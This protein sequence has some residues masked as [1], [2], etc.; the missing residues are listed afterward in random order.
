MIAT[1]YPDRITVRRSRKAKI[2][3]LYEKKLERQER[4][5]NQKSLDNLKIERQ[6]FALSKS[7]K[8]K[9][10]DTFSL[11]YSL[12]PERKIEYRKNKYIYNFRLSFVTLTLPSKQIHTDTEIK[13]KCLNNFLNIMRNRFGLKNYIW[14]AELQKNQNIHFHLVFDL[15]INHHAVRYYWNQS[16]ELLGYVSAY[17]AKFSKMTLS[18]YSAHRKKPISEVAAHFAKSCRTGWKN[19]G[20]EQVKA[21]KNQKSLAYYLS[22]YITKN[23]TSNDDVDSERLQSFGRSWSRSQSLSKI[24]YVTRW[25]WDSIKFHVKRMGKKKKFINK[26]IFDYCTVYYFDL[27]H[28]TVEFISWITK[29]MR[30]LGVLYGYEVSGL[31]N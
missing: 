30:S 4:K 21:I 16:I 3:D 29:H 25:D 8:R 9:I 31:T 24:K 18:E 14:I 17:S 15:Y 10:K 12:T 2:F 1:I 27:R 19:P 5:K 6:S 13:E 26:R 11:L 28:A 22:K 7:T 20:T 23:S